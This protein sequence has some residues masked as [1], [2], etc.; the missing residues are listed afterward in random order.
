MTTTNTS[1]DKVYENWIS[2]WS[3]ETLDRG[4]N[5]EI[6]LN[7][8][9]STNSK[10]GEKKIEQYYFS[11]YGY[12]NLRD[13]LTKKIIGIK[14]SY[15]TIKLTPSQVTDLLSSLILLTNSN[16]DEKDDDWDN[17]KSANPKKAN[18]KLSSSSFESSQESTVRTFKNDE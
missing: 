3:S 2:S 9:Q 4:V 17:L 10:T 16:L 1:G 11:V 7:Y 14:K 8:N 15:S 12:Q 18:K 6:K 5:C 13:S